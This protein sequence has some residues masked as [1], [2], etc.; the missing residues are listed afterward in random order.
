MYGEN[1]AVPEDVDASTI[2]PSRSLDRIKKWK[3][4]IIMT[5]GIMMNFVLA[6]IVLFI[7]E[8][9]C[10]TRVA[11]IGHIMVSKGSKA[12]EVGLK[13][14]DYVYSPTLYDE[15]IVVYDTEAL[16][17]YETGD[18]KEVYFGYSYANMTYNDLSVAK[19]AYAAYKSELGHIIG[20]YTAIDYQEAIHGDFSG[21]ETI[22]QISGYLRAASSIS[23]IKGT[24]NLYTVKIAMTENYLDKADKALYSDL[25][26]TVTETS[27]EVD[28]FKNVPIGVPITIAGKISKVKDRNEMSVTSSE[29]FSTQFADL[30]YGN[31]LG[32]K[33]N[34]GLPNKINFS[35]YQLDEEVNSG[36]GV[37]KSFG[38]IALVKGKLQG[39]IGLAMQLDEHYH[40]YEEAVKNTFKDFGNASL[41]IYRGLGS[42]FTPEGWKNVGGIIAI[43]V[44]STQILQ[45]YGFGTFMYFWA[46]ISVNLGIVNLLPFPGLDGWHFLVTIVEGVAHKELPK[47]FKNV[48]SAIGLALLFALMILVVVKDLIMVF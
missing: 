23:K 36:H 38:D 5:A 22:Y 6:L 18:P 16:L 39:K 12:E 46:V 7:Y 31:V 48:M 28:K 33:T 2:D 40:S 9:S 11:R 29:F 3:R 21:D 26:L 45:D 24:N 30:S 17:S 34:D 14:H 42:L 32:R 20:T 35:L 37:Q 8:A 15:G 13:S 25:T 27:N 1:D 44:S 41:L 19:H 4:A 47:K 10:P 43:G